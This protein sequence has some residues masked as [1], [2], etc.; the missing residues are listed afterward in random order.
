MAALAMQMQVRQWRGLF[1]VATVGLTC[2]AGFKLWKI[3]ERDR[4]GQYEPRDTTV[5]AKLINDSIGSI[6][7]GEVKVASWSDYTKLVSCPFN[8]FVPEKKV[9]AVKGPE[10]PVALPEKPL[11]DVIKVMALASAPDGR[12]RVVVKYK[13][14]TVKPVRDELVIGI[15]GQLTYPYDGEPYNGRL[16]AIRADAAVF[17]WCGKDVD[18]HPM[19]KEEGPKTAA[20]PEGAAKVSVDVTLSETEKEL[21]AAHKS[22]EKTVALPNDGG[23]VIGTKDQADLA[24][25]A[26]AYLKDAKLTEQKNADGKREL[27]VGNIR[28]TSYL[29]KTYGVQTGDTL[30]SINGEPVAT[31]AQGYAYVREHQDLSKYVVVVRRKGKEISKTILVNREKN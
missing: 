25:N 21:L 16:K 11:S 15:G 30:I 17:E 22:S 4:S 2:L 5:F 23:Y 9:E 27:V 6:N 20:G 1:W 3:V 28:P 26:E 29:G 24:N 7:Q 31:K 12:G 18:I 8:G 14:D 13:D 19:R 10:A